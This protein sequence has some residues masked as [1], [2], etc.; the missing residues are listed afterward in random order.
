MLVLNFFVSRVLFSMLT[1]PWTAGGIGVAKSAVGALPALNLRVIASCAYRCVRA[2]LHADADANAARSAARI[3]A[4]TARCA[5]AKERL[6]GIAAAGGGG[7][8]SGAGADGKGGASGS[9]AANGA[10]Q[11]SA[12]AAAT[13]ELE[14]G[15]A[16]LD[17]ISVEEEA[18]DAGVACLPDEDTAHCGLIVAEQL[19][20]LLAW[21]DRLIALSNLAAGRIDLA[22][23][24]G[25]G[26]GGGG[27][28]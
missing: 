5:A 23:G 21:A 15:L 8:A 26:G 1:E 24:G 20:A 14:E 22:L 11:L 19:P 28:T 3:A 25:G 27:G 16:A 4:E 9:D 18:A 7:S 6:R 12:H 2:A 13:K 10:G 17:A